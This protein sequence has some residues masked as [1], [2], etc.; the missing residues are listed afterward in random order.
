MTFDN[1][2]SGADV[3]DSKQLGN[4]VTPS[5]DIT[6][7]IR[8][9]NEGKPSIKATGSSLNELTAAQFELSSKPVDKLM[10]SS[11]ADPTIPIVFTCKSKRL[12]KVNYKRGQ[13]DIG[14]AS[15]STAIHTV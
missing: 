4:S 8:V 3:A 14:H 11:N 1:N 15:V 9:S 10:E 5:I 12:S 6:T 13:P 2:D 7:A